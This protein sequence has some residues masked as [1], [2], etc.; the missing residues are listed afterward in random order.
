MDQSEFIAVTVLAHRSRRR[1][2]EWHTPRGSGSRL[3]RSLSPQRTHSESLT[4]F[5]ASV[6]LHCHLAASLGHFWNSDSQ[7]TRHQFRLDI[8]LDHRHIGRILVIIEFELKSTESVHMWLAAR[9]R[10]VT[11]RPCRLCGG[12]G[13]DLLARVGQHVHEIVVF[14]LSSSLRFPP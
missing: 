13:G 1:G 7:I 2:R 3:R 4:A 8:S 9:H 10:R 11:R 5:L 14:S 6:L 12:G